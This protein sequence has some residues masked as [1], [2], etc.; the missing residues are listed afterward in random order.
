[1]PAE[2]PSSSRLKTVLIVRMTLQV[3]NPSTPSRRKRYGVRSRTLSAR[4]IR[5]A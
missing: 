4:S 2:N 5:T 1:M 3:P